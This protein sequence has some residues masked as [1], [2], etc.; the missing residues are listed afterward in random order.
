MKRLFLICVFCPTLLFSQE[1]KH[2]LSVMG[3]GEYQQAKKHAWNVELNYRHPFHNSPKWSTE[4]GI[5]FSILEYKGGS[6]IT[7]D[8]NFSFQTYGQVIYPGYVQRQQ[9]HYSKTSALRIQAG[10]NYRLF[11]TEKYHFSTGINF[12][13][14]V[15]IKHFEHGQRVLVP[16]EYGDT[17]SVIDYH[18]T[19]TSNMN[20]TNNP[21]VIQIQPHIDLAIKLRPRIWF[22][23]RLAYYSQV[24]PRI[25]HSRVQ[26]NVGVCFG[27]GG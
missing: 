15:L 18:Y 2:L 10:L 26:L 24:L 7:L 16:A 4:L 20:N 25:E 1:G 3:G 22:T 12:L 17:L 11:E 13:N 5:N 6:S 21:I 19:S 23:T 8:T 9:A 14:Q 27:F